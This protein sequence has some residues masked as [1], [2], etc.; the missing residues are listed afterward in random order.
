MKAYTDYPFDVLGDKLWQKAPIREV[1]VIAYDGDKYCA[2]CIEN[3]II[4]IKACYIYE[5]YGRFEEVP[6]VSVL[7]YKDLPS[8]LNAT[9]EFV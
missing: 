7:K 8:E 4:W 2:V 5:S 6:Q 9:S 1:S 3:H